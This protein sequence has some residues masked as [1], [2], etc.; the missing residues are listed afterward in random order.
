VNPDEEDDDDDD[1]AASKPEFVKTTKTTSETSETRRGESGESS[2]TGDSVIEIE[3]LLALDAAGFSL[4]S[5]GY[6]TAEPRIARTGIQIYKGYEIGRYDMDEV[7]VYRP[8]D[9][10][11]SKAAMKS[12]AHRPISLDHPRTKIDASNWKELSV[13]HSGGEVARDGEFVRVP[14]VLMDAHA[15]TAAQSGKSQLSV[16]YGADLRWESGQTPDGQL[17]DA[18]QQNIRANHIAL[19]SVARGGDKLRI[20][21]EEPDAECEDGGYLDR[22]FSTKERKAAAKKGQ[23]MPH[24]GFPV[25]SGQDLRNAVRAIGRAK[26]PAAAKAHI[27]KRASALGLTKLLP[28]SWKDSEGGSQERRKAM[29]ERM[30]NLD[31]VTIE[32]EDKDCQI[33]ERHLKTLNDSVA[34]VN[35]KF[36]DAQTQIGTFTAQ[37]AELSKTIG[38]KDGEI[39]AL[40]KKVEDGK[41]T[42]QML[43]EYCRKRL[44]VVGRAVRV[45]GDGYA[46]DNKTDAQI[47]RDVVV[48]D[49]GEPAVKDMTDENVLG[50][51]NHITKTETT[52]G[53]TR[54]AMSFS[55]RPSNAGISDAAAKAYDKRNENLNKAYLKNRRPFAGTPA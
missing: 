4:T 44:D 3:E 10:V 13:G 55:G 42:P 40:N 2:E 52:D 35:K 51:F 28:A 30:L 20:G 29:T 49:M 45:L 12:M 23:A 9:E 27:K 6:L 19:V 38:V 24:G 17:Y 18:M 25:K 15:I 41:V 8:P 36:G 53:N 50:A 39:A 54:L 7:R 22:E 31:G 37:V 26:N 48:S 32:L 21:D 5:D 43:D 14:L 47:R 34:D 1:G 33:L 16:G 11:F 46:F